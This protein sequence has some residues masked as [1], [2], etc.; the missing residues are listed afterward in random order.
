[1]QLPD[2]FVERME[3]ELGPAE[4]QALCEALG[5]EPSTS[6]RLNPYKMQHEKWG[7]ESIEWSEWGYKLSARPS[8]TLDTAFHAGAYYVQE[9]SSQFAGYI[10]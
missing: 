2:K 8:F 3:R 6:V 5:N 10:L 9:A 1:M 7:G 4:A